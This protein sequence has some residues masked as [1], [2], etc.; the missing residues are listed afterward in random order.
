[1]SKS[2]EAAEKLRIT[3]NKISLL[4]ASMVYGCG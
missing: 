2:Y 1:M 4:I 3:I